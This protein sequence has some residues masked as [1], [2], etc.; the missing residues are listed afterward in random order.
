M[1]YRGSLDSQDTLEP[2]A[3]VLNPISFNGALRCDLH[4]RVSTDNEFIICD[5]P[6]DNGRKI[7]L[8]KG[9]INEK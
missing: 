7:M 1:L 8:I 2:I 3:A 5:T 9:V 4:P 6:S